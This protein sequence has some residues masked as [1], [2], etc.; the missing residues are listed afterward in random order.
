LPERLRTPVTEFILRLIT[1]PTRKYGLQKP[2]HRLFE[3]HPVINSELLYYIRHGKVF[4]KPDVASFEGRTVRFTDGS[5]EEF[6]VVVAATGYRIRF[7]F[8]DQNVAGWSDAAVPLYL[9]TIHPDYDDLFF[10]GLVQPAGCI[11]P[12]ADLQSQLVAAAIMGRW[13]RPADLKQRIAREIAEVN[14]AY[15]HTPRHNIEVDYHKYRAVLAR[16]LN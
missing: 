11:W 2:D 14:S 6:D 13:Q 5:A 10:I 4:S 12:L 16:E 1:G 15:M 8:L 7:P 3:S 9:K